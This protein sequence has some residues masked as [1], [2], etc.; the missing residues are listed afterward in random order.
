SRHEQQTARPRSFLAV[1][2][3][4]SKQVKETYQEHTVRV[5]AG[6]EQRF[7]R[8]SRGIGG[9]EHVCEVQLVRLPSTERKLVRASF[10]DITERKE[11]EEALL[12]SE[13]E[14]RSFVDNAPYGI[15]RASVESDRLLSVNPALMKMLGY[16]TA[17]EVLALRL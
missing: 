8:K 1:R 5:L 16:D 13:A 15:T 6:E 14:L 3:T 11:A 7:E 10:I 9:N 2:P 12:R 4:H 17:S